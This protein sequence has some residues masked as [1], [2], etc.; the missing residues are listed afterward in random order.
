M[1][2]TINVG[3][4]A[5]AQYDPRAAGFDPTRVTNERWAPSSVGAEHVGWT[6]ATQEVAGLTPGTRTF[7][8]EITLT[9]VETGMPNQKVT[10]VF[11]I[12]CVDPQPVSDV[13]VPF[14]LVYAVPP[15]PPPPAPP[16]A[17]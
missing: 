9:P 17:A 7:H 13:P 10:Y 16:V 3:M 1:A 14:S 4:T 6:A 15:P 12:V 8:V 5:T 11:D 2:L